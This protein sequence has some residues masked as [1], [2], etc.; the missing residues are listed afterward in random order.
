MNSPPRQRVTLMLLLIML[1]ALGAAAQRGS[2][3]ATDELVELSGEIVAVG[4]GNP[5]VELELLVD[6]ELWTVELGQAWRNRRAGLTNAHLVKGQTLRVQGHPSKV[7]SERRLK[8]VRVVID[9]RN[10]DLFPS[11]IL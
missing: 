4:A 8:A 10:Y 3:V 11:H 7:S 2:G 5:Q 9:G 6:G 1:F